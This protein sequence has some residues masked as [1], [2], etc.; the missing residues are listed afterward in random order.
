MCLAWRRF[1]SVNRCALLG[2]MLYLSSD[3]RSYWEF[4][5]RGWD[6]EYRAAALP[7]LLFYDVG[8]Q[9]SV[10]GILPS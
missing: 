9:L 2:H 10:S 5:V 4:V 7:K 3:S 8:A 6:E 1:S